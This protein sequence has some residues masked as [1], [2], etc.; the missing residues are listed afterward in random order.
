MK[1][2]MQIGAIKRPDK[3]IGIDANLVLPTKD[4]YCN[5]R[6]MPLE[7]HS[8]FSRFTLTII[9]NGE[10]VNANIPAGDIEYIHNKG[11]LAQK[12]ILAYELADKSEDSL[13]VAYTQKLFDKKYNGKT[14][15]EVLLANPDEKENLLKTRQFLQ[16]NISRYKVNRYQIQAIDDAIH[17]LDS[18]K[19]KAVNTTKTKNIVIYD[20]PTKIPNANKVDEKNMT[21][22]YSISIICCPDKNYPFAINIMNGK[23]PVIKDS[24]GKMNA[25]M[26]KLTDKKEKSM[27]ISE[28]EWSH[29]EGQMYSTLK[30]FESMN[31]AGQF[32]IAKEN[33]YFK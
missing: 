24:N 19:L 2:P 29:L 27:L 31:F 28:K 8:N 16:D 5:E 32:Q 20:E 12:E 33:S 3:T 10:T 18:G 26:S 14:P 1:Y 15:A 17:L 9:E 25:E 11:L 7:M 30:N 21:F 22:V 4:E 6:K 23:A 13:S